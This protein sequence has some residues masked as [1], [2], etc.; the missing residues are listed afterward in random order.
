MKGAIILV[1]LS[2]RG[3]NIGGGLRLGIRRAIIV[4]DRVIGKNV[5][6]SIEG[7]LVAL[8]AD[9]IHLHLQVTFELSH[10]VFPRV[11]LY[12]I[13]HLEALLLVLVPQILLVQAVMIF[14]VHVNRIVHQTLLL[15]GD[16]QL[17]YLVLAMHLSLSLPFPLG[18]LNN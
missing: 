10:P 7:L 8:Q 18:H 9:L 3:F 2:L 5:K 12:V 1:N 4:V 14:D 13:A 15:Y 6:A 17:L 16:W 11:S